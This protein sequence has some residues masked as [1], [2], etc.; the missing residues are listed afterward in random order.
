MSR[1][2]EDLFAMPK[3]LMDLNKLSERLGRLARVPDALMPPKALTEAW[4]IA[5]K[6]R[7]VHSPM[8]DLVT[9]CAAIP[10][11]GAAFQEQ[12][13]LLGGTSSPMPVL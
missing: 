8:A 12:S 13:R 2:D 3:A 5:D 6:V 10:A 4:Q 7:V 1:D 11:L 9:K